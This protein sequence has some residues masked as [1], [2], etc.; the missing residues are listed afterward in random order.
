MVEFLP[1]EGADGWA[2]AW[3]M[4]KDTPN[5]DCALKWLNYIISPEGQ[6][7]VVGVTGYSGSNPVAL[8]TSLT[9]DQLTALH[10]YDIG[11]INSLDLWQEPAR[12]DK[13][14]EIWNA[15]KAAQ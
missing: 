1:E 2:D 14:I 5:A 13:Y 7:G 9:D 6:C 8:K 15:V 11:Y 4:V 3:Q 12:V 10:Q